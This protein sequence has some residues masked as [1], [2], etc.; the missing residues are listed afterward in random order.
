MLALHPRDPL[1]PPCLLPGE[2]LA[3][4]DLGSC[5]GPGERPPGTARWPTAPFL[6]HRAVAVLA[7]GSDPREPPG[8]LRPRSSVTGPWPC[9]LEGDP[10]NPRPTL[11]HGALSRPVV[12]DPLGARRC[13]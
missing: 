4:P 10:R 12:R 2:Y 7:R 1:R 13:A 3:T 11:R 6:R 9:R 5:A 8:G